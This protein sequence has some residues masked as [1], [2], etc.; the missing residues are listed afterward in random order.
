LNCNQHTCRLEQHQVPPVPAHIQPTTLTLSPPLHCVRFSC[1]GC[2]GCEVVKKPVNFLLTPTAVPCADA[3]AQCTHALPADSV[4]G[5]QTHML[6]IAAGALI[7]SLDT[8]VCSGCAGVTD[9]VVCSKPGQS[10]CWQLL[11]WSAP[12]AA[13]AK[14]YP[15]QI[16]RPRQE[17]RHRVSPAWNLWTSWDS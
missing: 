15:C 4:I 16:C 8:A 12:F 5:C 7:H 6:A 17:R 10:I 3:T 9:A 2:H 1:K 14:P 13:A 11:N